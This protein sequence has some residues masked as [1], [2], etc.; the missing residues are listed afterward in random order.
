MAWEVKYIKEAQDDLDRLDNSAKIQVLKA[1]KKVSQNPLP[2][3][4]GYG[5]P[6]GNHKTSKLSGYLKIKLVQLGYRV[7]YDIIKDG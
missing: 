7:V 5:K 3:P 4:D 2:H 1:I 6:L